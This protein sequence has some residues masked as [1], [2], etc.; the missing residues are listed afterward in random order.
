MRNC[1]SCELSN[2]KE[3]KL[4]CRYKREFVKKEDCCNGYQNQIKRYK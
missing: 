4:W 3:E 2:I 1:L